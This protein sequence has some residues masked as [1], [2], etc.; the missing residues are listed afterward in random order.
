MDYWLD[1]RRSTAASLSTQ[2]GGLRRVADSGVELW[3]PWNVLLL[4]EQMAP[5]QSLDLSLGNA[6]RVS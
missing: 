4:V 1:A 2:A 3:F 5:V 6:R